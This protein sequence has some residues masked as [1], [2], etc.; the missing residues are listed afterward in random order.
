[1][2]ERKGSGA[3]R[4]VAGVH[5]H[6]PHIWCFLLQNEKGE[7][8]HKMMSK[9]RVGLDQANMMVIQGKG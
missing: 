6:F 7:E 3:G 4:T 2:G 5:W 9:H 1:M 8:K